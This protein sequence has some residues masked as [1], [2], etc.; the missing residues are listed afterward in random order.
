MGLMAAVTSAAAFYYYPW[1]V[2]V[3]QSARVG[4]SLFEEYDSTAV[5]SIQITKFND[6]SGSLDRIRLDRS[7]EKWVVPSKRKYIADNTPQITL[8]ANS[9]GECIVL[10]ET[11]DQQRDYLEYGVL[12]PAD[13]SSTPNKSALGAKIVL[14]D[15]DRKELG[16][17]IV[18]KPLKD[19]TKHW[20]RIP[21]QPTVY[22]V[23][24]NPRAINTDFK[25]WVD[26]NLFQLSNQMPTNKIVIE[27]YKIDKT[28]LDEKPKND[29]RAVLKPGRGKLDLAE[30]KRG[31]GSGG[32]VNTPMTQEVS[33]QLQVIA[34]Q[35]GM[36]QFPDVLLKPA[37]VA[38]AMGDPQATVNDA[39][40][41]PLRQYGFVKRGFKNGMYEFDS[42]GGEVSVASADGV[43]ITLYRGSVSTQS[44]DG[45]SDNVMLTAS[46]DDSILPIVKQPP[47]TI[48]PEEA[49]KAKKAYLR[50]V[51]A[52]KNIVQA[53]LARTAAINQ[54]HAKWIY[55]VS[56][57]LTD[58]IFPDVTLP[59]LTN[60]PSAKVG[61]DNPADGE[62]AK[63]AV[64]EK[65]SNEKMKEE[66]SGEE[67]SAK[68]ATDNKNEDK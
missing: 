36:I 27:N 11:T 48:K 24:F 15:R 55:I 43:V 2:E 30:I 25:S 26:P 34:S 58:R 40:F 1:P 53:S 19:G 52:R 9:L 41:E 50:E 5:R 35:I 7:G 31:D 47:A 8:T 16:S 62:M 57:E 18:G 45:I 46:F 37:T 17:L 59:K 60:S 56:E 67:E 61:V 51:E 12:D 49:E 42:V 13:F 63:E 32:W 38:E 22:V 33:D 3:K 64:E 14:E 6:D 28:K 66:K 4:A 44:G 54:Q 39:I 65:M 10:E 23:E 68:E 29:Y 21:G 20:V